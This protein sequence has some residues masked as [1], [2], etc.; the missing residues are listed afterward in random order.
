MYLSILRFG[1]LLTLTA[2]VPAAAQP[3]LF[4][5]AGVD[6]TGWAQAQS[7]ADGHVLIES[8]QYPRGLWLHLVDDAGDALVG[9]QVEYQERPDSLVAI[10]CVDPVGAMRETLIWTRPEGDALRLTLKPKEAGDLPAGLS[11][12]DWRIDPTAEALL[13][14]VAEIRRV[15]WEAVAAFLRAHWQNQAGRVAV[16]FNARTLAI[17]VDHPEDV[18]TLVTHLQQTQQ[19]ADAVLGTINLLAMQVFAGNLGLQEGAILLRIPL[20]DDPN[21]ESV[22]RKAL[23]RPQGPFTPEDFASLTELSAIRK[24][25]LS[26]AG[27]EYFAALRKLEL[28]D[29]RITDLTPIS[30]LNSLDTLSL[31]DNRIVDL[32]PISQLKSLKL[33]FL[34]SNQIT[35]LTP[36]NE[37]NSLNAL[38]LGGNPIVDLTPISQLKNL[39]GLRLSHNEIDDL[40]P[41]SQL[42]SLNTL[43]LGGNRI[44]DLT[45]ISQ[46]KSLNTLYLGGNRIV[47]LTPISQLKSLN[48]LHL[49]GNRIVDLTPISQ[50]KNLQHLFLNR[51]RIVDLN[52]LNQLKSLQHL[53]LAENR[54]VDLTPISQLKNL[55][56]LFLNRN[57]IVDLTPISQLDSLKHLRL[58]RNPITDLGPLVA[59]SGLGD[60]DEVYLESIILSDQALTEHIPALKARGVTVYYTS[61]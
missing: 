34:D 39:Q 57:R 61:Q 28:Y 4:F 14:P 52:P 40:T 16:Q 30:Q 8:P 1:M 18:E 48:T 12:M 7:N 29:N 6:S 41:I 49:G 32:T 11:R 13:E 24:S 26:L 27:I 60:G 59:H 9:L 45:P 53:R 36:I 50:L 55:Q 58:S 5:A 2:G 43:Y 33:L 42:K 56:Y 23:G 21:L 25:I 37:L 54:I 17:E 15:G 46:L 47:D 22:V 31:G 19:P 3:E 10:R 38:Y 44:V 20:F 51:N 35:D